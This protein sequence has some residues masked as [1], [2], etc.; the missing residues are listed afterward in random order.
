M[1]RRHNV[2]NRMGAV[3]T[4][5]RKSRKL[6][7]LRKILAEP[8]ALLVSC[9]AIPPI[10]FSCMKLLIVVE[11]KFDAD[12]YQEY[13]RQAILEK[14][15]GS[16]Y[17]MMQS[18]IEEN[19]DLLLQIAYVAVD[20]KKDVFS[21]MGTSSLPLSSSVDKEEFVHQVASMLDEIQASIGM[22]IDPRI[23]PD[24]AANTGNPQHDLLLAIYYNFVASMYR[25]LKLL[26]VNIKIVAQKEEDLSAFP[27]VDLA[28]QTFNLLD[29]SLAPSFSR[30]VDIIFYL[31]RIVEANYDSILS[32]A[33][34]L[35]NQLL[36]EKQS[37]YDADA[38]L[39][40]NWFQVVATLFLS[41]LLHAFVTKRLLQ[42]V[43]PLQW[44]CNMPREADSEAA[45]MPGTQLKRHTE[46]LTQA[47]KK[48]RPAVKRNGVAAN[49]LYG[50][51]IL[52]LICAYADSTS[53]FALTV[54][55]PYFASILI[56]KGISFVAAT[57][58]STHF[59]RRFAAHK[60]ALKTAFPQLI[61]ISYKRENLAESAFLLRVEGVAGMPKST[62]TQLI[63]A[64][65]ERY[66]VFAD[67]VESASGQI[68]LPAGQSIP[69]QKIQRHLEQLRTTTLQIESLKDQ[70]KQLLNQLRPQ[71]NAS[72]EII[73]DQD[74]LPFLQVIIFPSTH[75]KLKSTFCDHGFES[76]DD[77]CL[78]LNV[79]ANY[80]GKKLRQ[81]SAAALECHRQF[82]RE[83]ASSQIATIE[84]PA[85][86]R[87]R[88]K[89]H[90]PGVQIKKQ[91]VATQI[92][93]APV[94]VH[95]WGG[96]CGESVT[97]MDRRVRRVQGHAAYL[98]FRLNQT[99]CTDNYEAFFE[100]ATKVA[101]RA[102]GAQGIKW[103]LGQHRP[104]KLPNGALGRVKL[105]GRNGKGNCGLYIF[106]APPQ[107][108][109]PPLLYTS[110][111]TT[112]G[113]H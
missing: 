35:A 53:F 48:V 64:T 42:S 73:Y 110:E 57:Y 75:D 21:T 19:H 60:K 109:R 81:L 68:L 8:W 27:E 37:A 41:L 103:Y 9:L 76:V 43:W 5:I 92:D 26:P 1:A 47:I 104:K 83:A 67:A 113:I 56:D 84:R 77:G 99:N 54:L 49:G 34:N 63:I 32:E 2:R 24:I 88:V 52:G 39:W 94:I 100:S 30:V 65:L 20:V 18:K 79:K 112:Y 111:Q 90:R 51:I 44:Y 6:D 69:V 38:I 29:T 91:P 23:D 62:Y 33:P 108:G 89:H 66:G 95:D 105:L 82:E 45:L 7:E 96:I 31:Q 98:F 58:A 71:L 85:A 10:L 14:T 25:H 72:C 97:S 74:G 87:R 36:L 102:M 40:T 17:D 55:L 80:S 13:I 106:R 61:I 28:M 11:H 86:V 70:I 59:E 22:Q 4:A 101:K 78:V 46:K 16:D 15:Y 12:G 50:L 93:E 107:D 3:Q